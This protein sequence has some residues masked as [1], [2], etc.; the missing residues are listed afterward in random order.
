MQPFSKLCSAGLACSPCFGAQVKLVLADWLHLFNDL[1]SLL[2]VFKE[3][4]DVFN[5]RRCSD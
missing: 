5:L 3:L 1:Q 4:V 2:D